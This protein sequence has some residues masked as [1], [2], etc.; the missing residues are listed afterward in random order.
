MQQLGATCATTVRCVRFSLLRLFPSVSSG[1]W[2]TLKLSDAQT[3]PTVSVAFVNQSK[4]L[5]FI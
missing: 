5:D 1:R 2:Q 4:Q 3:P